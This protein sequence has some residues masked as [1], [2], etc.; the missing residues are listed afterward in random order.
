LKC[1]IFDFINKYQA[2]PTKL[3]IMEYYQALNLPKTASQAEIKKAYRKL[4]VKYHPDKVPPAQ[5]TQAET[6]FKE[7]SEAYA[8]L[9]DE[10]KR[11]IYD[12]HGKK[13]LEQHERMGDM[14]SGFPFGGGF[15]FPGFGG[16]G[17][18][19]EQLP[20]S[21]HQ[22]HLDLDAFYHGKTIAFK[23]NVKNP[24]TSCHGTGCT[25]PSKI[26]TCTQCKGQGRITKQH[27]VGPGM[28]AQQIVT[29]PTCRGRKESFPRNLTCQPCRGTTKVST[30]T[31]VEYYIKKGTDYGDFLIEGQGDFVK[32]EGSHEIRGHIV[33]QVRPPPSNKAKFSHL[34]R[35]GDDLVYEH[36]L[37][38][39]EALIGFDLFIPHLDDV[40]NPFKISSRDK[41]ISPETIIEVPNKGMPI[42]NE[43]EQH[44][45]QYGKLLVIF[46]VKFPSHLNTNLKNKLINVFP[47]TESTSKP[48][49]SNIKS[50]DLETIEV[51]DLKEVDLHQDQSSSDDEFPGGIRME[52]GPPQCAQQ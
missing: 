30:S 41:V 36:T 45:G 43:E 40:N 12:Q 28:V 2:K 51:E 49:P 48:V 15:P 39:N 7:I 4:A 27:R 38:L 35:T 42:I 47:K 29:C 25:D 31:R 3:F 32:K 9:S 52:G 24:C 5:K 13:G 26:T 22:V 20:I 23:V 33:L 17:A 8:I 1:L 46:H 14:P 16:G 21:A 50:D 6:K 19:R 18:R 44:H 10:K 37:S 11:K 34:K